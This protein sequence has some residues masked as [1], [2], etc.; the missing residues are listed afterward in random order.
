MSETSKYDL[1]LE[2]LGSLEKQIYYFIQKGTELA[3][4]N[5][6][7]NNRI[8]LLERENEALKKKLAELEAKV[9]KNLMNEQNLFDSSF[10]IEEKEALKSKI[11]EMIAKI[12]YHL[13]S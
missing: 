2:E 8:T 5:Q 4:S 9:S 11:T 7:L 13:R 12:D 1:F 6:G 10:N 3:E